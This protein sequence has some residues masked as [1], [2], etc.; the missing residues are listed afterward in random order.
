RRK[1]KSKRILVI[2]SQTVADS[3]HPAYGCIAHLNS[4]LPNFDIV[5]SS[6]AIET[7]EGRKTPKLAQKQDRWE[8]VD[9]VTMIER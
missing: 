4:V 7:G 1:I 9:I 5:L 6:P 2:D 3:K 8:A